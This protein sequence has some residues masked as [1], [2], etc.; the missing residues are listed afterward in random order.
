[1]TPGPRHTHSSQTAAHP[2][3]AFLRFLLSEFWHS[4]IYAQPFYDRLP[5]L[6]HEVFAFKESRFFNG[7]SKWARLVSKAQ[8]K[9]RLGP[10]VRALNSELVHQA[11]ELRPDVAFIFRGAHVWPETLT[12]L[13]RLGIFVIGWQNDDPFS[14]R[15]PPYVW[16]HFKAGIP[17]YDHLFAYRA[18]N[19]DDFRRSGCRR[20]DLLRSFYLEEL[21]HP[22]QGPATAPYACDISF[23]GHW[24]NDGRDQYVQALLDEPG[25]HFRLWGTLWERSPLAPQLHARLGPILPVLKEQYNLALAGSRVCLVFLSHLNRDTYTRRCFEIPAT[26]SMMLSEFTAD[27][28]SLFDE[29]VEAEFFRSPGELLDK[30]RFYARNEKARAAI[31]ARGRERLLRDG[32]EALDRARQVLQKVEADM[33]EQR[34]AQEHSREP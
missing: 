32:H 33:T 25:L 14:P 9:L 4:H 34:S 17:L 11:R 21:N 22:V 30:A 24:E 20:V 28:A 23:C 5:R 15:Y 19:V 18:Q 7:S 29:G 8:D 1:M 6:G 31:A 2:G 16:R 27:L 12:E 13:R 10:A 3:T 26:G